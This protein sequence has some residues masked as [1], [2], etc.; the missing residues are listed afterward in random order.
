MDEKRW[1]QG[2]GPEEMRKTRKNRELARGTWLRIPSYIH[3][4][5]TGRK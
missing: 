2:T 1:E 4:K 5:L 3:Q